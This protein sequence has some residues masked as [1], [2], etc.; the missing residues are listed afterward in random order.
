MT[1][2]RMPATG[3]T[4]PG[5]Y[6]PTTLLTLA[7]IAD[8][9]GRDLKTIKTW[10]ANDRWPDAV[11]DTEG[12]RTRRVPVTD[13]VAAGDLDGVQRSTSATS[14]R[15]AASRTRPAPC[16]NG[17]SA[18]R[19]SS[20]RRWRSLTSV[21]APSLCSRA[22]CG[23][24]VPH[25]PA[26]QGGQGAVRAGMAS[27]PAGAPRCH[28][29]GDVD[30]PARGGADRWLATGRAAIE[31]G[32]PLPVPADVDLGTGRG[33]ARLPGTTFATMAGPWHSEYYE[34]LRRGEVDRAT[35]RPPGDLFAQ[36]VI[37]TTVMLST[38]RPEAAVDYLGRVAGWLLDRYDDELSGLGLASLAED[39]ATTAAR[40]FGG[41]LTS[42]TLTQRTSSYLATALLDLAVFLGQKELYEALRQNL[43][44]LRIVPEST[45]ADEATAHWARGGANVWPQPRVDFEPWNVQTAAPCKRRHRPPVS[46]AARGVLSV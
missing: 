13:P 3:T 30:L 24:A 41:S 8:L 26:A 38:F 31:A 29:A 9:L 18:S 21:L 27:E 25:E 43:S 35:A 40:P 28:P 45:K 37:A 6:A 4:A 11:Q 1:D 44:A 15:P 22:L 19:S 10:R 32:E 23:T 20:W 36:S 7:E 16:A 14:S 2:H 46:H 17:S 34:E 33:F 42:T 12:R 39:E 5:T